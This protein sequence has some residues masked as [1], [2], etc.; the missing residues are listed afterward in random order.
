MWTCLVE[1]GE[2]LSGRNSWA[3]STATMPKWVGPTV[4]TRPQGVIAR[5]QLWDGTLRPCHVRTGHGIA[6]QK[7]VQRTNPQS[8]L[9]G[10]LRKDLDYSKIWTGSCCFLQLL[11]RTPRYHPISRFSSRNEAT[12]FCRSPARLADGVGFS[13]VFGDENLFLDGPS[14]TGSKNPW[15]PRMGLAR[16]KKP[17][18]TRRETNPRHSGEA[19]E[20]ASIGGLFRLP[21]VL[22]THAGQA[23]ASTRMLGSPNEPNT[24]RRNEPISS[25]GYETNPRHFAQAWQGL[26]IT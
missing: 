24:W 20:T 10:A 11:E 5:S 7:K 3:Q 13:S 18:M 4:T 2:P 22:R 6:L 25:S 15:H 26:R 21:R 16:L 1:V 9:P 14:G 23:V 17:A 12:A 19:G 8:T